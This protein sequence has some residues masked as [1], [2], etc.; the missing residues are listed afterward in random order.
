MIISSAEEFVIKAKTKTNVKNRQIAIFFTLFAPFMI[1]IQIG[2]YCFVN[3]QSYV[4]Q[5]IVLF[6]NLFEPLK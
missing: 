5:L 1:T 3:I 6:L 2:E 4:A